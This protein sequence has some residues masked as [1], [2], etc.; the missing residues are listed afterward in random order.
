MKRFALL[1]LLALPVIAGAPGA[2][3]AAAATPTAPLVSAQGEA[4]LGQYIVTVKSGGGRRQHAMDAVPQGAVT[5]VFTKVVNGFSAKLDATQLAHLRHDPNVLKVAQAATMHTMTTQTGADWGLD[6]LDAGSGLDQNYTYDHTGKGVTAYVIDTGID[7][8]NAD[9]GGRASVGVDVTGGDGKD[10]NGHGTHVAGTIG[11]TTYGVAKGVTI[12]AVRVLS[13]QGS[14]TDADVIAG[15][16]WVAR[17][18]VKPAV[19]NMSLGGSKSPTVD[20]AAKRLSGAGVFL[21]VAAGNNAGD[22]CNG[23]PSGADGVLAVAADDRTDAS[24]G[25]TN[26]GSCVKVYAPGVDIKSDW[27]SGATRTVSGTSMATPHVVGVAALYKEANGDGSQATVTDW[28][29]SHAVKN[30]ITGVPAGTPNLL[31]NTGGL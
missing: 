21:A 17:N 25:F 23:S 8:S 27:L 28:I 20:V 4:A 7:T 3:D 24:A 30:A 15:M 11:G 14:G 1:P 10:C 26:Y 9:F 16:D 19:A 31:L 18:A 13:C 5:H 22:A 12:K 2:V 29:T 6:R